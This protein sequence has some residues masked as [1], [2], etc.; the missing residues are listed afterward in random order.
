ML[1]EPLTPKNKCSQSKHRGNR[2]AD[3]RPCTDCSVTACK[4]EGFSVDHKFAVIN[5]GALEAASF[6][7]TWQSCRAHLRRG[8]HAY[9][10]RSAKLS[11]D[12][13]YVAFDDLCWW[14]SIYLKSSLY[15]IRYYINL[16]SYVI[17]LQSTTTWVWFPV[18]AAAF[19]TKAKSE[20]THF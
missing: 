12:S 10:G 14:R 7:A 18:A 3:Y 19:L 2:F 16:S 20:N 11:S 5:F 13:S 4:L 17:V 8:L 1:L 15:S 9:Y 6:M